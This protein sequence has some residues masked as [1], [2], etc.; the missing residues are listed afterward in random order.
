MNKQLTHGLPIN[1]CLWKPF[2]YNKE[3]SFAQSSLNPNT[4]NIKYLHVFWVKLC[5]QTGRACIRI[6]CIKVELC[7]T[8]GD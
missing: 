6:L 5:V 4:P 3:M 1:L 7:V 8:T 2:I